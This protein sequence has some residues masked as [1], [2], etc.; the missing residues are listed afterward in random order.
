MPGHDVHLS[1]DGFAVPG[2]HNLDN[3][4][5][6]ALLAVAHGAAT[7]AVQRGLAELKALPHRMEVVDERGGVVWIN[8]SKATNV[9][10]ARVG[11][12]GLDRRAV[13]LL[14]GQGKPDADGSLGFGALA[15]GLARHRVI[16]FGGSGPAIA[17]ELRGAGLEVREVDDLAAAVE[18]ARALAEPGEAVLLSPGCASFDEFDDFEHRGRAFRDLVGRPA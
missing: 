2:A 12:T 17:A 18:L 3:A 7:D 6:A 16:T 15:G 1:L 8:D 9:D 14:G 5:T 13:V 10:A 11:H 4:A